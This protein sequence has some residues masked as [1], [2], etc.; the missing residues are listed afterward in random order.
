MRS[1]F[2]VTVIYILIEHPL[3]APFV[4]PERT[5]RLVFSYNII[6]SETLFS[7][8]ASAWKNVLLIFSFV[9]VVF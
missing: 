4:V 6:Y 2:S 3:P 1:K 9:V 5:V 8:I 7:L